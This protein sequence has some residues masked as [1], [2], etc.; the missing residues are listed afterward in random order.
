M[1]T[2]FRKK[3]KKLKTKILIKKSTVPN[4]GY[5]AF[6]LSDIPKGYYAPYR[7]RFSKRQPRNS[8]Y[9]WE[10]DRFNRASGEPINDKPYAFIDGINETHWTK[11]VNSPEEKDGGCLDVFQKRDR[12]YYKTKRDIKK[13]E[14]LFVWYGSEY[15]NSYIKPL[16]N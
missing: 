8:L 11:F 3:D 14:E 5:G 13:G 4:A 2:T 1:D 10:V 6:A 9:T 12:I 15:Y 7:G 16:K